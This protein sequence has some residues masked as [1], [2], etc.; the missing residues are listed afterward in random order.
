MDKS[1]THIK[2][3]PNLFFS[4]KT[5][6]KYLEAIPNELGAFRKALGE[7]FVSTS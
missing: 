3:F 5:F 1:H 7:F 2:L 4:R 6:S